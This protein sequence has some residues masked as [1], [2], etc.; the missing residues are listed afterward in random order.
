[1]DTLKVSI[2]CSQEQSVEVPKILEQIVQEQEGVTYKIADTYSFGPILDEK[3]VNIVFESAKL[4][5]PTI[6]LILT[7]LLKKTKKNDMRTAYQDRFNLAIRTL[8]DKAPLLCE[9]MTDSPNFSKY[10]FTTAYGRY[11]WKYDKGEI[12]LKKVR[13]ESKK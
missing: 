11:T 9:E 4:A 6:I 8:E 7:S 12:S 2:I 10:T 1:M 3:T 13:G 5:A